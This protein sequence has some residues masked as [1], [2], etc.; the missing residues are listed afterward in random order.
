MDLTNAD[1][2]TY[3]IF[4]HQVQNFSKDLNSF[5]PSWD[6]CAI[7]GEIGHKFDACPSVTQDDLQGAYNQLAVLSNKFCN[8][9]RRLFP[10]KSD[11][12]LVCHVPI[13][14]LDWCVADNLATIDSVSTSTQCDDT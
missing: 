5:D 2:D 8:G 12:N 13:Y 14:V 1:D 7:C 11:V 3:N 9:L 4:I 6:K 10:G